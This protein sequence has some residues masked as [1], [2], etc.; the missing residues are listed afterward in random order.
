MYVL[1]FVISSQT[2]IVRPIILLLFCISNDG[3]YIYVHKSLEGTL[4][5]N[6]NMNNM[7]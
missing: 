7:T 3:F 1:H 4:N 2:C 6:M 5:M